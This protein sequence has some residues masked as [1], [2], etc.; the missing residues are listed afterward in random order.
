MDIPEE[1][2]NLENSFQ[3]LR[4]SKNDSSKKKI[5][6]ELFNILS[7]EGW[8][9][10]QKISHKEDPVNIITDPS[11]KTSNYIH[12]DFLNFEGHKVMGSPGNPL[13]GSGNLLF[14]K[15]SVTFLENSL[16]Y[17]DGGEYK[18]LCISGIF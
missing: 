8:K 11:S 7:K 5:S 16:G 15:G 12:W 9:E 1:S 14:N 13:I 3:E 17:L 4:D 10:Y 18:D 2:L 6:E